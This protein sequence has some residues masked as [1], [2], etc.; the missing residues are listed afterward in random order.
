MEIKQLYQIF[1]SHPNFSTDSRK[2]EKGGLF[3]ALKGANFDGNQFARQ[4]LLNG[5]AFAIVDDP[6][7][8]NDDRFIVVDDV[9]KSLQDLAR[10]YRQQFT[11][12][13]I[14]ITGSNGKT[15]TKELIA[16]VLASQ[17]RVHFTKGNFNNHIGVPLTLLAMPKNTEVAIIEMGANHLG[18]IDSLCRIAAPTH[19]LITNIGKAHL[20]GFGS[21]E[22][23]KIAKSEL[24]RYLG[25]KGGMVFI[26]Q[27]ENY[28]TELAYPV[29]HK[30]FY[31]KSQNPHPSHRPYEIKELAT[32]PFLKVA[33]LNREGQLFEVHTQIV[34][35]YNFNNLMTAIALGK[36]FKVPAEKAKKAME[37]YV[38]NNNRSQVI[39]L[40]DN[41]F[42]LDAYNANPSS[43]EE[44]LRHFKKMEGE[45]KIAILGD[46]LELGQYSEKEHKDIAELALQL[47]FDKLILVGKEFSKAAKAKKILH[48]TEVQALKDWWQKQDINKASILIKGSRGIKLEELLK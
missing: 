39:K 48:F 46:M 42:L 22:G 33:F 32:R 43:M 9:L 12:P 2:V 37:A 17:Y 14:A 30:L 20:E 25:E 11:I 44:A 27:D 4:A 19:G 47:D 34:G 10:F 35:A 41:T 5:A 8:G 18:E 3:F 23:V 21:L 1:K 29:F 24:Y 15:T 28:L 36:Y 38:S 16:A 6:E 45:K 13:I 7:I 26:N 31:K 40:A